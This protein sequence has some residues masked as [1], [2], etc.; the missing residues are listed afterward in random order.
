MTEATGLIS[1]T[2]AAKLLGI[3]PN[4]VRKR[5][6][7][8]VYTAEW[9]PSPHGPQQFLHLDQLNGEGIHPSTTESTSTPS[10]SYIP[11]PQPPP[12]D[13]VLQQVLTPFLTQLQ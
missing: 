1:V 7:K 9:A 6:K 8:G 3:H 12:L 5:I 10:L 11:P 2:D 4:T 13:A